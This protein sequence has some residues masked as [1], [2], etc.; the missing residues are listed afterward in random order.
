V[1]RSRS[2]II[3]LACAA[4]PVAS[5]ATT[6]APASAAS[7]VVASTSANWAGYAAVAR[8]GARYRRVA[9]SWVQPA[10]DC[11]STRPAYSAFWV[12]LGGYSPS[13]RALEQVG[14]EADCSQSGAV[15]YHAWYELVPANPATVHLG[16]RTGDRVTASVVVAGHT[17]RV[18][19][20]D[21]TSGVVFARTLRMRAPDVSSAEWIAE[22]P[23]G[24]DDF[25]SCRTLPLANFGSVA[26]S[27]A[28]ASTAAHT[29]TVG[30]PAWSATAITLRDQLR[31]RRFPVRSATLAAAEADPGTLSVDG[32]AFAVTWRQLSS[33]A[34]PA[35]GA[36]GPGSG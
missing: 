21:V 13:S 23:S 24:C 19:I 9:A 7:A 32:A 12:G 3:A 15:A 1:T 14:T 16:L 30:D 10:A 25:G 27:G 18:R 35:P 20:A 5:A 34:G 26:F 22:A 8:S 11:T 4:A 36:I 28:T 6:A 31:G 29:G 2:L 17:V 33:D